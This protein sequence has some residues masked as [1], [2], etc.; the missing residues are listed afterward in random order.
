MWTSA[1]RAPDEYARDALAEIDDELNR[2]GPA[3][4]GFDS[5]K[6]ATGTGSMPHLP[7]GR[8][9]FV[10]YHQGVARQALELGHVRAAR[11]ALRVLRTSDFASQVGVD[12]LF[13]ILRDSR[14]SDQEIAAAARRVTELT[15]TP[16]EDSEQE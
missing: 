13:A 6:L 16:T 7:R 3:E 12:D 14:A 4:V 8:A 1:E 9:G 2:A 11:A 5:G 15:P 10:E